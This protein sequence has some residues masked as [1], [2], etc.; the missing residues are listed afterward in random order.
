LLAQVVFLQLS[1]VPTSSEKT[2][3]VEYLADI[4]GL[5]FVRI[6]NRENMDISEYIPRKWFDLAN[7][8]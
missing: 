2:S 6:N 4:T 1:P 7:S 5:A 8:A 3:M